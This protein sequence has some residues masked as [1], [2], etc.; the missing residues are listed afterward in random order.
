[1]SAGSTLSWRWLGRVDY[2]TAVRQQ[3]ALRDRVLASE[4]NSPPPIPSLLLLEHEP[5]VTLGRF[6]DQSNLLVSPDELADRGI[7]LERASRGGDVTYHGPGQLIVYPVVRIVGTVVGFLEAIANALAEV[8]AELG[9]PGARWR[10]DPAGL[11]LGDAKLAAC[12]IHLRSRVTSHGFA[13]N[14]ST[15]AGPWQLI[16]PCGLAE[17]RVTSI[18]EQRRA[19]GLPRPPAVA[20]VAHMAAPLLCAALQSVTVSRFIRSP[21]QVDQQIGGR[22]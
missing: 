20:E 13:F 19:R 1:M 4:R 21:G 10:R 8:A 6:A 7:A 16:N 2:A 11:W 18:A 14:V 9:V 5:V 15:P 22:G 12:G 3:E 17:S